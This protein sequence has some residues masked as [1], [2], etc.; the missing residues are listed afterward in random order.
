MFFVIVVVIFYSSILYLLKK[1]NLMRLALTFIFSDLFVIH[2][3]SIFSQAHAYIFVFYVII[4]HIYYFCF[5]LLT[6]P[7]FFAHSWLLLL[8]WRPT[9]HLL[10]ASAHNYI[11]KHFSVIVQS[12]IQ[13]YYWELSKQKEI[14]KLV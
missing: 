4:Q 7:I 2:V 6:L 13:L 9:V 3:V 14:R 8:A 10:S 5:L 12:P 11:I 1:P